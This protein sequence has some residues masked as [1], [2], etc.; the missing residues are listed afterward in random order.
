MENSVILTNSSK[1]DGF[2]WRDTQSV[3]KI[4]GCLFGGRGV[5]VSVGVIVGNHS[6]SSCTYS[7]L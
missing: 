3:Y 2:L 4:L 5:M 6:H 1:G 7:L